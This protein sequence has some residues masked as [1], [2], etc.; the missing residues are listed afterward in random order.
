PSN[1]APTAGKRT[2]RSW[3]TCE[4]T[5]C[6]GGPDQHPASRR[7]ESATP[8]EAAVEHSPDGWEANHA[9]M[10]HLREHRVPWRP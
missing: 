6:P 9:V 3:P 1:T 4:N 2:T 8:P 5:G 7:T 10:A